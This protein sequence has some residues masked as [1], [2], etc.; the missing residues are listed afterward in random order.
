MLQTSQS[1]KNF[2]QINI[3]IRHTALKSIDFGFYEVIPIN[4]RL[5]SKKKLNDF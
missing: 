5:K 4:R 3:E 2:V 1:G